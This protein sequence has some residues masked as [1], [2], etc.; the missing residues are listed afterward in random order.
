MDVVGAAAARP[1][2]QEQVN[3]EASTSNKSGSPELLTD[4]AGVVRSGQLAWLCAYHAAPPMGTVEGP[5]ETKVS[6]ST[7]GSRI[8]GS[9]QQSDA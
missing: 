3:I 1:T 4:D 2:V 9:C 5:G 8:S 6:Y 7:T